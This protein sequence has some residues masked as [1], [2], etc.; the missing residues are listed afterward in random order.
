[1]D[2]EKLR[3]CWPEYVSGE[4]E[5]NALISWDR[6]L[7]ESNREAVLEKL[8]DLASILNLSG[9]RHEFPLISKKLEALKFECERCGKCCKSLVIGVSTFDLLHMIRG[10]LYV[11]VAMVELATDLPYFR[12]LNKRDF[13]RLRFTLSP[14]LI[15]SLLSL[16]PSLGNINREASSS[17]VFYDDH[18]NRCSIYAHRPL[19]CRIYPVG[20]VVLPSGSVLCAKKTFEGKPNLNVDEI[21]TSINQKKRADEF[22]VSLL[23]GQVP[24]IEHLFV[25]KVALLLSHLRLVL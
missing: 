10:K 11:L 12:F 3:A 8:M 23:N 25:F 19:E 20:N 1:M 4:G 14:F 24:R 16:N 6:C 13:H 2:I 5:L 21:T 22:H 15:S 9:K 7:D 17:C 18:A